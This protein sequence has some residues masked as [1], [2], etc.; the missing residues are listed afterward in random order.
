MG[1][2]VTGNQPQAHSPNYP[3]QIGRPS[4]RPSTPGQGVITNPSPSMAH[5]LPPGGTQSINELNAEL[6]RI[7]S[8][9]LPKLKQ[10]LM[11]PQEKEVQVMTGEEK[12]D[13]CILRSA[14]LFTIPHSIGLL[15]SIA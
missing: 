4:S 1:N 8:T 2:H 12:V 10:D 14:Y 5:R 9:L 13:S 15:V 6:I 11:I 7:P 3:Q